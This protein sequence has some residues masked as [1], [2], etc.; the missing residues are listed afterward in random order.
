MRSICNTS[1][2]ENI[3]PGF[4]NVKICEAD[5]EVGERSSGIKLSKG[6]THY[7]TSNTAGE[8]NGCAEEVCWQC[9]VLYVIGEKWVDSI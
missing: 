9:K 1:Q 6:N 3:V 5:T 8:G 2:T 7:L 4:P